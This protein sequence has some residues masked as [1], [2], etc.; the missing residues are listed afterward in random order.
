MQETYL[1]ISD[2]MHERTQ[3]LNLDPPVFVVDQLVSS[4]LCDRLRSEAEGSGQLA[5]SRLGS[6]LSADESMP[7]SDRRTSSSMLIGKDYSNTPKLLVRPPSL[8][9]PL[10]L[11]LSPSL[12]S[13]LPQ[14][15]P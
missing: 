8:S 6:G 11:S 2:E 12:A 9:Q 5:R 3:V 7:V 14:E 4:E 13:G 1:P 15:R 10:Q